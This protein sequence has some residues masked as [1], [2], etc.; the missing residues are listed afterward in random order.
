[1]TF[2]LHVF[3]VLLGVFSK[4]T[5][6]LQRSTDFNYHLYTSSSHFII[7]QKRYKETT[8]QAAII[9]DEAARAKPQGNVHDATV[10]PSL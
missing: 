5:I 1:M 2:L 4:L 7:D 6:L 9:S 10:L 3:T 8:L